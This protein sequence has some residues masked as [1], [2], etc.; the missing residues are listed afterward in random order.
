MTGKIKKFLESIESN[1]YLAERI[2]DSK[3]IE[4]VFEIS[5]NY[6]DGM[7][8]D[9]FSQAMLEIANELSNEIRSLDEDELE[10][11]SGGLD[12]KTFEKYINKTKH[13]SAA[14]VLSAS[15]I[16]GTGSQAFAMKEPS[17]VSTG[18]TKSSV[19]GSMLFEAGKG[20]VLPIVTD[21]Y[22]KLKNLCF[23]KVKQ[24]YLN[25]YN[26]IHGFKDRNEIYQ[27]L[28]KMSEKI[29]GQEEAKNK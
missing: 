22:Y 9:E 2:R 4:E 12:F 16:L 23:Q 24:Q 18:E 10:A 20:A 15:I 21:M 3:S 13:L 8:F 26:N 29:K 7:T 11:I 17:S 27:S 5:K 28:L 6:L 14:A 19:L 1:L 25:V